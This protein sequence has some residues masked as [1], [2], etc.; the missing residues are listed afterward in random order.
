MSRS[1]SQAS[2]LRAGNAL[3]WEDARGALG[4]ERHTTGLDRA[5]LVLT[6]TFDTWND[7]VIRGLH[8]PPERLL[9]TARRHPRVGRI[10]VANPYRSLPVRAAKWMLGRRDTAFP[11]DERCRLV[12]PWRIRRRD[13]LNPALVDKGYRRYDAQ[14]RRAAASSGLYQ[15]VVVT[16]NP[17]I[18]AFAPFE[19]ARS[20]TYYARDDW[21]VHPAYRDHRSLFEEAYRVLR[22]RQR[23]VVAVSS[24]LLERIGPTGESAVVPNGV[25]VH[26][27]METPGGP[28]DWLE[29]LPAPRAVYVGQLDDRLDVEALVT[30]AR[31]LPDWSF[32]LAGPLGAPAHLAPALQLPNVTRAPWMPRADVVATLRAA[33]VALIPHVDD[34]LTRAMSPLK[35]YEYLA[36]GLPIA[37]VDLPPVR[38]VDPRVVLASPGDFADA[39]RRAG[40]LGR[41]S[42]SERRSALARHDWRRRHEAILG[43]A[44]R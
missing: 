43:I 41:A 21:T 31:S 4:G 27:W 9:A 20:V 19:W 29:R 38:D 18:A 6:F 32:V 5:D 16:A 3:D 23:R 33:E 40:A 25:D 44:L 2:H 36:A 35:L 7:A 17:V 42:E 1:A 11:T 26:E 12:T 8:R 34:E 22:A 15:P 14:V 30:S 24:E 39:V 28:P 13:P 37:S 10:L